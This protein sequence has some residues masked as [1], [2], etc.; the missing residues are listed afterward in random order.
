MTVAADYTEPPLTVL[1]LDFRKEDETRACLES[2]RAHLK[3]PHKIVLLD[4]GGGQDYPWGLYR[5]GLCDVL[6][7]KRVGRGGGYGQTDLFRWCDT[8]FALFVQQD[9][10]LVHDIDQPTF[11]HLSALLASGQYD[12][13]DLNGDQSGKGIWTDRAHLI[14]TAFFNSLGP[15]PNGGPGLDAVPW[16]E[17]YL[18]RVFAERGYKIAHVTPAVFADCGKWS[19]RE[20]GDGLYRHRCDQKGLWV[21][22]RPTHRT[23]VY[24]PLNESEWR[25]MLA[26]EWI[27]GAVPEAWKPH[28]FTVK[29]W[30]NL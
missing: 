7:S 18:Q 5:E 23:E 14:E 4:N 22:R 9:Q 29:H 12:C 8:R 19:V 30:E 26:G 27:D 15:F 3:I 13:V 25:T 6:I 17:A 20:A 10:V 2:L 28:S 16:N 24:P 11:D 21:L 1:V